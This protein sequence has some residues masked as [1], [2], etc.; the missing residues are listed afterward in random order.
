MESAMSRSLCLP[1]GALS[2][3][4][5]DFLAS[6]AG[7][8]WVTAFAADHPH[9]SYECERGSDWRQNDL[10]RYGSII[11]NALAA[12][13]NPNDTLRS[14][15]RGRYFSDTWHYEV[16]DA[17]KSLLAEIDST[18][19]HDEWLDEIR[20]AWDGEAA[21]HDHSEPAD[22]FHGKDR[23][24]VMF[25]FAREACTE[26]ALIWSHKSW[27]ESSE[28]SVGPE[29]QFALANLGYGLGDF[30]KRFKNR[31]HSYRSF[32]PVR[33]QRDPIVTLEKLDE[34]IENA[35]AQS[36][37][38]CL[39]GYVP[40]NELFKLDLAA[41]ITFGTPHL[42]TYNPFSGTFHDVPATGPVTIA[43][44]QGHFIDW[45]QRPYSPIDIC[46]LMTRPYQCSVKNEVAQ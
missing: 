45:E 21:E 7:R 26:D 8:T 22:L 27:A 17:A 4:P 32:A 9:R 37:L 10:N 18:S 43:K 31:H 33:R 29:L 34:M 14:E 20:N 40:I 3:S 24:E 46:C 1:E 12:G 23:C 11:L 6:D 19:L 38:F 36:F 35:C 41:P 44:G 39:Y 15:I 28:L 16:G 5:S 30:R 25:Y 42:A 13:D 2:A